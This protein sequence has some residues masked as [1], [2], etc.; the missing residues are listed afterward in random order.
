MGLFMVTSSAPGRIQPYDRFW[1]ERDR[2]EVPDPQTEF[3]EDSDRILRSSTFRRLG[4]VTQVVDPN[5]PGLFRNRS[6]HSLEVAEIGPR[7]ARRL[8]DTARCDHGLMKRINDFGGID[9]QVVR[10]ACLAHDLGHPPFGHVGEQ[11]LQEIL[12]SNPNAD[13]EA[14]GPDG[15]RIPVGYDLEDGF[16]GNAQTFRIVTRLAACKSD[17]GV[18]GRTLLGAETE[19]CSPA[20]NLTKASLAAIQKYHWLRHARPRGISRTKQKWGAYD[21]EGEMLDWALTGIRGREVDFH[22][23]RRDEYRCIDAQIMDLA[24][25][26]T[27]AIHDLDDFF[28][29]GFIPLN[30]LARSESDFD[31]FFQYAWSRTEGE[32][33]P[34]V[35]EKDARQWF[36]ELRLLRFPRAPYRGTRSEQEDLY[37]FSSLIIASTVEATVV[38]AEGF[39]LPSR[40]QLTLIELLKQLT[41]YYVIDHPL[42]SAVRR[43]QAHLMREL[44]RDLV[45][46]VREDYGGKGGHKLPPSLVDYLEVSFDEGTSDPRYDEKRRI[47]RAVTDYIAAL[48]ENQAMELLDRLTGR[49]RL[50]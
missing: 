43:G 16:E 22:G 15:V 39:I 35:E 36:N 24:D 5:E 49:G 12:S 46:W 10:V 19:P 27:Y 8:L 33:G 13:T 50:R 20:F 14:G 17:V 38:T 25:D 41:W 30:Q 31:E 34:V 32:L 9:P 6:T 26:I 42:L 18:I 2:P 4:N 11:A 3:L 7:I 21:S 1:Q 29:A 44:F 28:R 48:T 47:G 23:V 45:H 37:G 40:R